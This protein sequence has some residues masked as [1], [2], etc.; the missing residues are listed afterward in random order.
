M[1]LGMSLGAY[2]TALRPADSGPVFAEAIACIERSGDLSTGLGVRNNAGFRALGLGDTAAARAHLE[3]AVRAAEAIGVSHL[4]AL[5]N[6]ADVMRAEHDFG[7]ARSGFEDVVRMSRRTG[8]KYALAGAF[9]GLASLAADLGDWPRAAVLYGAEHTLV[10]QIGYRWNRFD[11][12]RRQESLDQ[13]GAAL[14][15]EQL[16]Q[17]YARGRALSFDQ[18]IDLALGG[19]V[20]DA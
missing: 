18:A 11:A 2:A 3:A 4:V 5:G 10:D 7:S 17:A 15:A 16:E 14:G 20:P 1:L 12:R 19:A 9:L 13:A 8:N 6:L